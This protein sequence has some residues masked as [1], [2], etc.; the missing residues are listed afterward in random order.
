LDKFFAAL[1]ANGLPIN[2]EKCVF[3]VPTLEFLG[4]RILATGLAPAAG[5]AIKIKNCPPPPLQRHQAIAT[6]SRHGKL[7]TLFLAKLRSGVAP[8]NRS[9]EGRTKGSGV[10]LRGTGVFPKS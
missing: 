5:H 4:Y 2:L 8:F 10:D 7:L 3:A 9:P 6:F 1:A